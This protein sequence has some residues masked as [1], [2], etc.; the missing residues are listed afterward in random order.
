ME[1][2]VSL[3]KAS[4]KLVIIVV[5][6]QLYKYAHFCD[7]QHPITLVVVSQILLKIFFK[8]MACLLP[9][10]LIVTPLSLVSFG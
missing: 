7:I 10:Y 6:D 9:L 4:N 3:T 1:F 2:I 5:V 8:S